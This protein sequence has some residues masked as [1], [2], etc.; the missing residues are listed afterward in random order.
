M[1]NY[2]LHIYL[3]LGDLKFGC[4]CGLERA[5]TTCFVLFRCFW[6][7]FNTT[8]V[9][10]SHCKAKYPP[11]L[12][13]ESVESLVTGFTFEIELFKSIIG[14]ATACREIYKKYVN[15]CRINT[16]DARSLCDI[17]GTNIVEL[18]YGLKAQSLY[19]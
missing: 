17:N 18:L 2:D 16:A 19:L 10:F 9:I 5:L 11:I 7:I 8:Y 13:Y 1:Y 3:R 15:I 12:L 4:F 6:H 14:L